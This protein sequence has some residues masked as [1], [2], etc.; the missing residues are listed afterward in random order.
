MKTS[1][2]IL[3]RFRS[4]NAPYLAGECAGF[5]PAYA[6]KLVDAGKAEFVEPPPGLDIEGKVLPVDKPTPKVERKPPTKRK[7]KD[8]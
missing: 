3:V 8:R 4:S 1:E 2:L 7:V 5:N 6:L